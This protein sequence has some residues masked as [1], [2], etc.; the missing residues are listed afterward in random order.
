MANYVSARDIARGM[1]LVN[2]MKWDR[3]TLEFADCW[4]NRIMRKFIAIALKMDPDSLAK[5]IVMHET[6]KRAKY[7]SA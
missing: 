7:G 4:W 6:Y 5:L 2:K 3:E 1:N